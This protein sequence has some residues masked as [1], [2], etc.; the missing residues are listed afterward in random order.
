MQASG[1]R[2]E[3][4]L[5]LNDSLLAWLALQFV[6]SSNKVIKVFDYVFTQASVHLFPV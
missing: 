2:E 6:V 3:L 4:F 5:A 1:Y